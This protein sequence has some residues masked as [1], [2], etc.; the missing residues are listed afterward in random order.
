MANTLETNYMASGQS[1][2]SPEGLA[3][4]T[5]GY[6]LRPLSTGEVLD[7]TFQLYRS[8][9]ALFAS[10]AALPAAVSFI[11][12]V[13]QIFTLQGD[14]V[15]A[16]GRHMVVNTHPAI[17]LSVYAASGLIYFALYGITQAATTWAVSEIYL[18]N[19]AALSS[20][21][22]AVSG[23]WF[24]YIL[25][26]LRQ[27]WSI[28]WLPA[29][30][31]TAFVVLVAIN[32]FS[33]NLGLSIVMGLLGFLGFAALIYSAYAALRVSLAVPAAVLEDLGPNAAVRRSIALLPERKI[34]IFLLWLLIVAM[35]LVVGMVISVLAVV[36]VTAHGVERYVLQMVSLFGSFL[37]RLV[38]GP[39]GA[40]GLCL[41]YFDE[42]V[43]HEGFDIE[44]LMQRS[45]GSPPSPAVEGSTSPE[46]A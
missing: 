39:V 44:F 1:W 6:D 29:I 3:Q 24:R 26:V 43:R 17:T 46:P 5:A 28:F 41:F 21:W 8:R 7:R 4:A 11:S 27:Y 37:S 42:R 22:K 32:R 33:G 14:R 38:I 9:F 36:A 30:F 12:G 31:F 25:V 2:T 10:L 45:G 23:R 20:A 16:N 35:G 18:G 34:R 13:I 19:P 40:I 15:L